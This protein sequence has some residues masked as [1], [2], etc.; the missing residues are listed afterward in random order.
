FSWV[1]LGGCLGVA[2]GVGWVGGNAIGGGCSGT[3]SVEGSY[4]FF[5]VLFLIVDSAFF[6]PLDELLL[7]VGC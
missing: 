3:G 1:C 7:F 5:V 4:S 2:A 6:V